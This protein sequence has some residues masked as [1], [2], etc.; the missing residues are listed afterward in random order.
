MKNRDGVGFHFSHETLPVGLKKFGV[1]FIVH[2]GAAAGNVFTH[3]NTGS[4]FRIGWNIPSDFGSALIRPATNTNAPADARD[5]RYQSGKEAFSFYFFTAANARWIIRDIFLDGNSFSD[6]HNVDKESLVGEFVVGSSIVFKHLKLSYAQVF[7][8]REFE[9]Q[10]SGQ[11]FGSI[12]L[13][14]TY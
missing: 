3:L 9:L 6:S 5:P 8:S 2:A 13:S 1:D 14:Y 12:S 4:E 10:R 11:S 7:R